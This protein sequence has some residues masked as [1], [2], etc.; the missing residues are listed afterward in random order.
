MKHKEAP[1]TVD[2]LVR[3]V[4]NAFE[5]FSPIKS[6]RIFLTLQQCMV[7]IMKV[8]GSNRYKIPH[9]SKAALER[10]GQLPRQIKCD[11]KLVEDV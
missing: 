5:N 1:K 11:K 9:M 6:N 4:E 7:E 10:Q 8:G 2:D 3:A